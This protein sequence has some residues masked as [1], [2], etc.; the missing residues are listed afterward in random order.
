MGFISLWTARP[1]MQLGSRARSLVRGRWLALCF[2]HLHVCLAE[3]VQRLEQRLASMGSHGARVPAQGGTSL[4]AR[5][6]TLEHAM[7]ALLAAQEADMER[8]TQE[9][10]KGCCGCCV[11]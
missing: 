2:D 11:M 3:R 7:G 1:R 10:R 8:A 6:A 9:K 5:V 4:S